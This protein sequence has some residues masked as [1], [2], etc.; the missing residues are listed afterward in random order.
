MDKNECGKREKAYMDLII[1]DQSISFRL[2]VIGEFQHHPS[3][4]GMD[5]LINNV[6]LRN[7][8][9]DNF[10]QMKTKCIFSLNFKK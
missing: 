9:E 2:E 1:P 6:I 8:Y 3:I 5:A 4:N 7:I 10:I